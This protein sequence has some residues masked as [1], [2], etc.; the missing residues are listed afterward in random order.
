[1]ITDYL[2]AGDLIIA[3]LKAQIP[4]VAVLSARDLNGVKEFSQPAP[5][6]Q[7]LYAGD[8]VIPGDLSDDAIATVVEQRWLLVVVTRSAK[9]T[10]GGTGAREEA[11][12]LVTEVIQ[13]VQG[14]SLGTGFSDLRRLNG[15]APSFGPG[16]LYV[17]LMYGTVV[18]TTGSGT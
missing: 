9:D 3:R 11:G 18:G 16:V 4:N 6:V 15:P 8:Q 13:A 7:V 17:P 10:R 1:M 12:P 2:S 14:Y 5:A